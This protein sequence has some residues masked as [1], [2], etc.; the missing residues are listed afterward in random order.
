M[1]VTATQQENQQ[2]PVGLMQPTTTGTTSTSGNY[3]IQTAVPTTPQAQQPTQATQPTQAQQPSQPAT[4]TQTP[5][6]P[7]IQPPQPLAPGATVEGRLNN[8]L[9][10]DSPYMKLATDTAN[11]QMNRRGLM[12][13]SIAVG[14]AHE[15]AIRN[16]LPIAQQD[17]QSEFTQQNTYQLHLYDKDKTVN[18]AN[19]D[20][21]KSYLTLAA[22]ANDRYAQEF[23]AI[24][25]SEMTVEQ[26]AVAV[27]ELKK[28]KVANDNWLNSTMSTFSGSDINLG[29]F[30]GGTSGATSTGGTTTT[31]ASP[32]ET[33]ASAATKSYEAQ[34][35]ALKAAG[36]AQA[37][38]DAAKTYNWPLFKDGK[39]LSGYTPAGAIEMPG[40]D[41]FYSAVPKY[42]A[43]PT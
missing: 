17:A 26:K 3:Q 18:A 43:V 12:Q 24:Q 32:Y 23:S 7:T 1:T 11:Q 2:Q 15:A 39:Y 4:T 25:R 22:A 10:S 13:S 31:P 30:T 6:T 16:A 9:K 28:W 34:A 5:A 8:L 20:Q 27:N 35:A 33:L 36:V 29:P 21:Q 38:I 42:T 14:A 19:L 40:K 37:A 41:I